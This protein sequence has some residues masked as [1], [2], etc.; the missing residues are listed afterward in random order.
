MDPDPRDPDPKDPDPNPDP[1]IFVDLQD[2][3]K[4]FFSKFIYLLLFEGTFTLFFKDKKVIKKSQ[5]S[6]NQGFYYYF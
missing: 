5:N 3:N 2:A 6:R 4:K 1:A